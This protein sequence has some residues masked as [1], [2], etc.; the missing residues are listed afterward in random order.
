MPLFFTKN[1]KEQSTLNEIASTI[2]ALQR[3]FQEEGF[4]EEDQE[5]WID[6]A[7][8]EKL[9][10]N[11]LGLIDLIHDISVQHNWL[12]DNL[13]QLVKEVKSDSFSLTS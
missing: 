9:G 8:Y 1:A 5:N 4:I 2:N 13:M 11:E 12:G 6:F 7:N 3:Q 10:H